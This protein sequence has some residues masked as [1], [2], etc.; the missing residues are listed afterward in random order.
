MCCNSFIP[1][2]FLSGYIDVNSSLTT[3]GI[4]QATNSC[5]SSISQYLK[6]RMISM[7]GF[8]EKGGTRVS[9]GLSLD[10]FKDF[11]NIRLV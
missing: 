8:I 5:S 3:K 6:G 2:E 4:I 7:L 9:V 11:L 1:I 10:F